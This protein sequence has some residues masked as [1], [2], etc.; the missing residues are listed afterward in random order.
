MAQH[1]A[2]GKMQVKSV[3]SCL[4]LRVHCLFY[5]ESR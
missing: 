1:Q 5:P 2:T 3:L 4:E